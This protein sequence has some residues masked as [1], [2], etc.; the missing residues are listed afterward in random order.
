MF[1]RFANLQFAINLLF[2]LGSLITIGTF[3]KQDQSFFFYMLNYPNYE[4]ILRFFDWRWVYFFGFNNV[5]TSYYFTVIL[6]SFGSSLIACTFTTQLPVLRSFR[7]WKFRKNSK[8]FLK[9]K[10]INLLKNSSNSLTLK[11][12]KQTHHLFR[13]NAKIYAYSGLAGRIAPIFVHLSV[14][15]LIMSYVWSVLTGYLIQELTPRGEILHFQNL[16]KSGKISYLPQIFSFRVNDFWI[17][18]RADFKT[19]QFYSSLS[20]LDNSGFEIQRKTIF[21]NEPYLYK[22]YFLLPNLAI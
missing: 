17:T 2:F 15:S 20:L 13:Q 21:I 7:V 11:L 22:F 8:R 5:Y 4:S 14:L 18:Y 10:T 9:V 1:K 12:H 6:I 3:V 19:N 16:L